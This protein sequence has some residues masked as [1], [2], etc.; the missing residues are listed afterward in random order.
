M[1]H[2][3]MILATLFVALIS[4]TGLT[5]QQDKIQSQPKTT[6]H[7]KFMGIPIDGSPTAFANKLKSRGF[8]LE[9]PLSPDV[10]WMTGT[11]AGVSNSDVF[12]YKSPSSANVYR[13]RVTFPNVDS[14]SQ[15]EMRYSKFKDWLSQKYLLL[16]STEEFQGYPPSSD[17]DKMRKLVLDNCT[18][19]CEY[20]AGSSEGEFLGRIYL[21]IR[22]NS[23]VYGK[24]Y[25][26]IEY[27]DYL[28][29]ENAEQGFIDDL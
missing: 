21:A 26:C 16:E 11:F 5:A 25:V 24:G 19:L 28:N 20:G 10:I 2:Y 29:G 4:F 15:L 18:Y 7:L 27:Q 14:W 9:E 23:S 8:T 13:V 3:R 22:R 17:S 12:I 1:K 6:E